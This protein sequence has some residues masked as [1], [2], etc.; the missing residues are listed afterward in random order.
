MKRRIAIT[1][2]IGS[3]KSYVCRKLERQG[4][5]IYD[6]DDAAKRLM[7]ESPALRQ[8]LIGLIGTDAYLPDGSLNKAAIASFLLASDDNARALNAIVHPAV[9]EDFMQSDKRWMECAI[10]YESGFNRL[11]DTVVAVVAPDSLRV[12][13][14]MERDGIDAGKAQE[15]IA[16]QM[17]TSELIQRAD[18]V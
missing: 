1:G 5:R 10:L 2:G 9:A 16:K 15:W 3:G 18:F 17:P 6:C 13:R 4:I 7:R 12:K 11:V 14:I 8:S